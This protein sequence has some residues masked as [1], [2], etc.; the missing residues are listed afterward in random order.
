MLDYSGSSSMYVRFQIGMN[1]TLLPLLKAHIPPKP[2]LYPPD[3]FYI[4]FSQLPL[5]AYSN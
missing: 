5:Q 2:A 1:Q 4:Y 3:R